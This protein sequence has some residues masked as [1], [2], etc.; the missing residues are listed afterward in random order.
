MRT[1]RPVVVSTVLFLACL[2][3]RFSFAAPS[4][5]CKVLTTDQVT[6]AM[7]A[8]MKAG[9]PPLLGKGC[10]WTQAA[11]A[12]APSLSLAITTSERFNMVKKANSPGQ[13]I[14]PLQGFGDDSFLVSSDVTTAIYVRKGN[15]AF[16][17]SIPRSM[18]KN[19]AT[20]VLK[21]L[22]GKALTSF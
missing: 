21:T 14:T 5:A 10:N 1:L 13:T 17:L 18:D 15:D 19:H 22:A 11:N 20:T 2:L 9:E 8:K 12:F 3:P 4:D 6:A 7:G 16:N